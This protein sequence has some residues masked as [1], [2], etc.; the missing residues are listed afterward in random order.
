MEG[1]GVDKYYGDLTNSTWYLLRFAEYQAPA[2]GEEKKLG[3]VPHRD[4]NT[5]SVVCQ[6]Q[7]DGLEVQGKDGEWIL[8]SPSPISFIVLAGNGFRVCF[9]S[10]T[11]HPTICKL[12]IATLCSR[13]IH[14]IKHGSIDIVFAE[15]VKVWIFLFK[16][17]KYA[18]YLRAEN[19]HGR[20]AGNSTHGHLRFIS[21]IDLLVAI[22][23]VRIRRL[24]NSFGY[25]KF[26]NLK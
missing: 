26:L 13:L 25:P 9:T 5:M 16:P 2:Q 24:R 8:A 22:F 12:L 18:G 11:S 6:L 14:L 21:P 10:S 7:K 1:L 3:Y 17:S 15:R 20:W 4:T 23:D 19:H